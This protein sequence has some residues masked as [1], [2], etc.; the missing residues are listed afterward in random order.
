[1]AAYQEVKAPI[2]KPWDGIVVAIWKQ[3]KKI[4]QMFQKKE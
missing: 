2:R 1:V 3:G 4:K